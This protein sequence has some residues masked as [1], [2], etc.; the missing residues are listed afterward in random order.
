MSRLTTEIPANWQGQ[1]AEQYLRR[2][3]QLTAAQIRSLKFQKNGIQRNGFACRMTEKLHPGDIL[4]ISLQEKE[5][6][7][8][9]TEPS[10]QMPDILYEDRDVICVWK[11]AGRVIHPVAGH[12]ADT[13]TGDL[14]TYFLSKDQH[15]AVH[16]IGRLDKDTAGILVFAKNRIA[17]AQ[18]WRQKEEGYFTK[19]YLAWCEGIFP[20]E[21]QK[22][23]Q[24]IS[25]PLE[26]T[27]SIQG[28]AQKM[29]VVS[30]GRPAVTYFQVI[31][32]EKTQ[33]LV[34]LRLETGRT[35]QIR[36][37]MA[38]IGHPLMGDSL[39]G[40]GVLHRDV[41]RLCAWKVSFFQPFTKE[42]IRLEHH[43]PMVQMEWWK[44]PSEE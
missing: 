2:E 27:P 21:A 13:V 9:K 41:T 42:K 15:T 10:G 36:V 5:P 8:Q 43:G 16:S 39:Y 19:E 26:K 23:E 4:E 7:M 29:Q 6:D 40:H 44:N 3:L 22:Q 18:L 37:H 31:R 35:H 24:R 14:M 17:A 11:P 34:R 20:E 1:T 28:Q 12:R 30:S 33:A 25:F 38:Y 32:Q